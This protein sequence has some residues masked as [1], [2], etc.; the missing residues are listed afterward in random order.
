MYTEK[1]IRFSNQIKDLDERFAKGLVES[2]YYRVK[3][4]DLKSWL[5]YFKAKQRQWGK[6]VE[7]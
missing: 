1:I 3:R 4:Q 6:A 2:V 7:R 5:D